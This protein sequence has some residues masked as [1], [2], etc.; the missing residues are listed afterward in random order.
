MNATNAA[1][2]LRHSVAFRLGVVMVLVLAF[3]VI[4]TIIAAGR[5]G[6]AAADETF[7]RLLRGA[8]LQMAERVIVV[9][10]Q[11]G[12][13][14]PVSAFEL[15]SLARN[16]RVF[17]RVEG[18]GN[19]TITGY[20]D[21]PL[22]PDGRDGIYNASYKGVTL[23]AIYLSRKLAER[24]L[25]GSVGIV[26][27]QSVEERS[28]LARTITTQA[29]LV[30]SCAGAVLL[31]LSFIALRFALRPLLRVE[32]AIRERDARDLS[33]IDVPV[34][35]E[36]SVLVEAINRFMGRLG[37]RIDAMQN[38]VADAAHQLRTPITAMRVQAQ[39]AL[40]EADPSR[41]D[42]LHRRIYQRS[43]GLGRL[44]DQLLSHALVSHRADSEKLEVIDLRRVAM[45][46]AREMRAVSEEP[47]DMEL[48]E[49]PVPVRGDLISLREAIKNLVN[50]AQKH[51]K[52]PVR[53][54]VTPPENGRASILVHDTGI[55]I[56]DDFHLR[57]GTRFA[58]NGVTPDSAGLGLA[59]TAAVAGSH[60]AVLVL[61]RP[62]SGGFDIGLQLQSAP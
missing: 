1:N 23:R 57:V 22:P 28:A 16:D 61:R 14:L 45:E 8:A 17:Y 10:G 33:P 42:R 25:S 58:A 13:D 36:V 51:G 19:E 32:Q 29:V 40:D 3:I 49:D 31:A 55:G 35:T 12:I 21:L 59:I 6:Q 20:A 2:A 54:I 18:T 4:G 60:D 50:N 34:P 47:I 41:L 9:D 62:E 44:A 5:Y 56:P 11:A 15:L 27:A 26:V 24:N 46:T 48:P 52:P 30:I 39:L 53:L 43:V 37:R 38:L 7:D